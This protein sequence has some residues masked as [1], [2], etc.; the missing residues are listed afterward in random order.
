MGALL[1][2]LLIILAAIHWLIEPWLQPLQGL[3]EIHGLPWLLL[4]AGAW[5]VAGSSRD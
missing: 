2:T 5:L 4:A 3:F 1:F